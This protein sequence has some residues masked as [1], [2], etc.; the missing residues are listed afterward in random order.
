MDAD[1]LS[2]PERIEMQVN[3]MVE[4]AKVDVVGSSVLVFTDEQSM[5]ISGKLL[6]MP[7]LDQLIKYNMIFYCCLQHPTLMFRAKTIGS[8]I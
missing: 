6:S 1:D 2:V 4:N 8:Q 3:F 7:T 5:H